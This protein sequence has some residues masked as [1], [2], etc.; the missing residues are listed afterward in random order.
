MTVSPVPALV[1]RVF[2]LFEGISEGCRCD[3]NVDSV[4]DWADIV[5][6]KDVSAVCSGDGLRVLEWGGM[7]VA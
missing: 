7:E 3:W 5:G 4:F 2:M 1:T 6:V